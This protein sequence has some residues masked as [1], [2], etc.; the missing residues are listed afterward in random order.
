MIITNNSGLRFSQLSECRSCICV[1]ILEE[2]SINHLITCFT[3]KNSI[4]EHWFRQLKSMDVFCEVPTP[5][6]S[7]PSS[8]GIFFFCLYFSV[9]SHGHVH[10]HVRWPLAGWAAVALTPSSPFPFLHC[11]IQAPLGITAITVGTCRHVIVERR[12]VQSYM[13]LFVVLCSYSFSY[14]CQFIFVKTLVFYL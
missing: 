14:I 10:V 6:I 4:L 5:Y 8:W 2:D 11:I 13:C 12:C 3:F 9:L 1:C 7:L